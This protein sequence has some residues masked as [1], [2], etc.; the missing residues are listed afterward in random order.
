MTMIP[1]EGAAQIAFYV[2]VLLAVTPL[3]GSYMARVYEGDRVLLAR[4]FGVAERG[5]YRLLRTSPE[6]EQ[7]WKGYATS[8]LVFSLLFILPLYALLRLQG[9][10]P[11]NPDHLSGVTP[12]VAANTAASFVTNTNWQ[13]YGGESTMSYLSQMAG[14][15]VQNFISAAVGMAVLAA[16]IRGFARRETT[17][18][19]N[20]WVDLYRTVAYIL[21]PICVVTAA[22]LIWQGVPE[23]F[24]GHAVAH[25]VQGHTQSIARGPVASQIAIKQLGT[26]GGGYYNANSSVPFENPTGLTN[27]VEMLFILVIGSSEV[28]MFGKMVRATR[29]GWA[30]LSVMFV[31]MIAGVA[32]AAPAEQHGSPVLHDAGVSLAAGG[33]QPGG[34]MEGKEVRFGIA[35]TA[36]W[37]DVT[38]D[39]SNGSVNGAHDSFTALGGAVPLTNIFIGEVVFGGVGSG[40]YGMLML[41]IIAV[42]VG[43]LMVGRT[44]EYLGKKIEARE[45]KLATIGSIVVPIVV[46]VL[47]AVAM[48]TYA[49]RASLFNAGPHG[50]TEAFYAYASQTNNNGSAFAG[51]GATH[52]STMLGVVGLIVGRF[53]P[54]ISALAIGG[55]VAVKKTAPASAGTMRTD[56]PTFAVLLTGVVILLPALT[57]LPALVL[58]P[59]VEAL[60]TRLF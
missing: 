36:L 28:F 37:A 25:T 9:H 19:G 40:L 39:A 18:L 10:L 45:M 15:A 53:V 44:P 48:S 38:T 55:S 43:G 51:Y 60:T 35:N 5:F 1:A 54:L 21:L 41:V 4:W 22:I 24:S 42:F 47:T 58:G 26:N 11:L 59:V 27:F 50:F 34:N 7:D 46:L 57:I 17:R 3:L 29:Q 20:F 16:M 13:Y 56:G 30:I 2:L 32:V 52:F 8:V 12:G 31:L 49:G 14:L 23:T 6:E 33:S